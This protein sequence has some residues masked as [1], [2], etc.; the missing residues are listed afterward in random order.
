MNFKVVLLLLR[1]LAGVVRNMSQ[2]NRA[3]QG[4]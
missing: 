4:T 3:A 1:R 2:G